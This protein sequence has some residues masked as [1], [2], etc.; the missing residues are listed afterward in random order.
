[1]WYIPK[2]GA[3]IYLGIFFTVTPSVSMT[4][5]HQTGLKTVR[6]D[7]YHGLSRH[8]VYLFET[9]RQ[10]V[11]VWSENLADAVWSASQ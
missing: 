6:L 2:H 5:R 10:N 7:I 4:S 11:W 8:V 9:G 1:M 3:D